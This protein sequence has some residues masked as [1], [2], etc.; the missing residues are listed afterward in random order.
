MRVRD[1]QVV[2]I[3]FAPIAFELLELVRG[4][5]AEDLPAMARHQR[6]ELTRAKQVAKIDIRRHRTLVSL[7]II[8][9]VAKHTQQRLQITRIGGESSTNS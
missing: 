5:A 7:D 6:D 4:E 1:R 2:D 3:D 9:R 8:E